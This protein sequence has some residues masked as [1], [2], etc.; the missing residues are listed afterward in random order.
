MNK[1]GFIFSLTA[2]YYAIVFML[3]LSLL[4]LSVDYHNT[5]RSQ[6]NA[7]YINNP[8]ILNTT[9]I[10]ESFEDYGWCSFSFVYDANASELNIQ[11]ELEIKKYCEDYER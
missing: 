7:Y 2:I 5:T 11:S 3:F 8:I 6:E 4:F 10:S 1:K 9:Y